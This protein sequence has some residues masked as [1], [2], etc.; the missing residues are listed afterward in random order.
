[1]SQPA[2]GPADLRTTDPKSQLRRVMG[3]WD[4]LLF[5]VASVVGPR[6]IAAAARNGTS[7]ISLWILAATLFFLPSTYSLAALSSRYPSEGGLYAWSKKAFGEFHGFVAGWTYWIYTFFYFP[8]LLMASAAMMAY[9]GGQGSAFLAQN[10]TFLMAGSFFL[11]FIAVILNIIGLNVGKWLQNAGGIG[12]YVPPLML[13]GIALYLW[14]MHGSVTHFTWSNMMPVW[15]WNTVN[16]WPQIAFAFG[17]LELVS[18]MSEEVRDPHKTFP[19]AILGSGVSIAGLYMIGTIA[20]LT[21]LPAGNVDPKSGVFQAL[22]SG[23]V[24]LGIGSFAIVASIFNVFGSA[25]G[26]GTTV[27]GVSR[28]PF[29]VGID[30][31]L[32]GAFGKIH[33]KWK[34]PWISILVQAGISCAILLLIQINESANSAYQI[35]V[36]AGTVLY[37]I[38]F[39]Y[40]YAAFIKLSY[41]S[42]RAS[43]RDAVLVPGGKTGVWIAGLLGMFVVAMGIAL[44]FVPPAESA[45]KWVFEAKLVAGTFGGILL[46]LILYFRGARE[47]RREAAQSAKLEASRG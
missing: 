17:G 25:G 31:Y 11:L 38:P 26:I 8:G 22:T 14:H 40:I 39:I 23:S 29:V 21:I 47:K 13:A 44:S 37:F 20:I 46:G 35:L 43:N 28:I 2:V 1:M 34:T 33:P 41:R 12:T 9:V 5:N 27:A 30:R 42:D 6:W 15:N 36:D 45:N 3:F 24:M 19:R 16:F 10:R 18:A 4:V 7:S 32:P